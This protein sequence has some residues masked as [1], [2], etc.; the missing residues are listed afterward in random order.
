MITGHFLSFSCFFA[1]KF[2]PKRG[3]CAIAIL[4]SI[5]K[6]FIKSKTAAE[7]QI[8]RI[9]L[10]FLQTSLERRKKPASSF[11]E[12][13]YQKKTAVEGFSFFLPHEQQ[14]GD[15]KIIKTE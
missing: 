10:L 11:R 7:Q 9:F 8:K 13:S 6:K 3:L 2:I 4:Y 5:Q 12:T 1:C 15:K 14:D